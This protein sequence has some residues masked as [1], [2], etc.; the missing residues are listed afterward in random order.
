M[1]IPCYNEEKNV[2]ETIESLLNQ[3]YT[4]IEVIA[5]NDGSSDDTGRVLNQLSELHSRLR[6]IHLAENQ[7]KAVALKTGDGSGKK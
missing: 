4:N 3:S 7:G 5:V 1:I 2:I 6:V